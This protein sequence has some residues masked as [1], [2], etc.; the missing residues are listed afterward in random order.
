MDR[1]RV[2]LWAIALAL[3]ACGDSSGPGSRNPNDY[4][5]TWS[6]SIAAEPDCWSAFQLRFTIDQVDADRASDDIINVVAEWWFP[7]S[8]GSRGT[9]TGNINWADDDFDLRFFKSAGNSAAFRGGGSGTDRLEGIFDDS[10]LVF[11]PTF[12]PGPCLGDATATHVSGA[13]E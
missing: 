7:S 13:V 11:A 6:L 10:D 5:G 12:D 1:Y 8:A 4:V 2:R 9:L 3:V